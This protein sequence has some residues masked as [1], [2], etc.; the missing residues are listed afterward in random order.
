MVVGNQQTSV[1]AHRIKYNIYFKTDIKF[2]WHEMLTLGS[3]STQTFWPF[4]L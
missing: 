2:L 4:L 1:Q 3:I